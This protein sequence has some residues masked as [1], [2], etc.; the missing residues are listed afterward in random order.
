MGFFQSTKNQVGRDFGK[1]ISNAVFGDKHASVYRRAQAEARQAQREEQ[2]QQD[3][4]SNLDRAVLGN[5]DKVLATT[6][7]TDVNAICNALDLFRSQMTINGW[8]PIV[9]SE[10]A[11]ENKINNKYPEACYC[12][13]QQLL[14]R[15]KTTRCPQD[16]YS[17]YAAILKTIQR[18]RLW[19]RFCHLFILLSTCVALTLFFLILS[20]LG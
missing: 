14:F 19:G 8:K 11:A 3:R 12:K 13:F 20:A 4:L 5:V 1:V 9:L 6:V 18:K 2:R 7:P 15:L 17:H 10:Q 16:I